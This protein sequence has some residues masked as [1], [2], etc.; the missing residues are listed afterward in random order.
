MRTFEK[1][2]RAMADPAF[3]PHPVRNL[4]RRE[5][6][7]SV[8]F[9]T[10]D[11][12]YKLKKPLNFGFLDYTSLEERKRMCTLEVMLNQ[13]LSHGVYEGVVPIVKT[14]HSFRMGGEGEVVEYAVCMKQLP[15]DAC[16]TSM[17]AAGKAVDE[18]MFRLGAYLADFYRR[19]ERNEAITR[20]GTSEIIQFNTEENF[21]QLE[22][23]V[24]NLISGSPFDFVKESSRAFL[25]DWSRLFEH[26]V[27]E[28]RIC[29][30]HGDLRAEHVYLLDG[31]QIIDC[32]EFN[33]RFRYG[34]SAIDMAFLHMD[35]ERLDHADLALQ[36]LKGY[37]EASGDYG[38]YTV[39]DFYSCYRALVKLKVSCLTWTGL[40]SGKRKALMEERAAQYLRLAFSF[41]VRF[42]RPAIWVLCGLPGTGK[43]TYSQRLHEI[44]DMALIRSDEA[45]KN[46]PEYRRHTGPVPYG[47]G[48]YRKDMRARVYSHMLALAQDEVKNGRSVILDATFSMRKWREE[49]IRLAED[50]DANV[51][52][53][54]CVSERSTILERL[55]RRSTGEDGQSDA[56][57]M[58]LPGLI[59]ELEEI[60]ELGPEFHASINTE[61]D[62]ESNMREMLA[63]A[64][65]MKRTQVERV[66][67]R[68]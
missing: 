25:R 51:L 20:Y 14:G 55:G 17:L 53:F 42:S 54:E 2:C 21:I 58:N 29:D 5:T 34:D 24:G 38:I 7:I 39:L 27:E 43:S 10:G 1:I 30:G 61:G 68:L 22:P 44:Y 8:V 33:E 9:L 23:F 63:R 48:I 32:I 36:V 66:I 45:R 60:R 59:E 19:S 67:A 46:L 49:A 47:E 52:F 56:R 26:R 31:I 35:L 65:A 18:D 64:Y 15:D 40:E 12:V 11:R 13:R 4:E 16:L 62:V 6:H 37:T 28:G 50:L 41:A 3:Y 57:A